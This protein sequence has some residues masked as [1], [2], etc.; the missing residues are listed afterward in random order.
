MTTIG[1]GADPASAR[2]LL[3]RKNGRTAAI[4][5]LIVVAM[6]G[7]AY[8]SV[9]LYRLFCQVTGFAGTTQRAAE[10]SV[11]G[12]VGRM[13]SVRFDANVSPELGGRSSPSIARRVAIGSRNIA[14]YTARNVTDQTLVGTA[15]FN[16][17]PVQAGQY[18]PRSNASASPSRA[19]LRARK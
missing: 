2:D 7:L 14:L 17:T 12:A 8:A 11:P 13:V 5:A 1:L 6:I 9:P 18:F 10:S 3:A 4:F 15:T 19:L 16:V